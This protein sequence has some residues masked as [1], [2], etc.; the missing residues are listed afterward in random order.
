MKTLAQVEMLTPNGKFTLKKLCDLTG[1]QTQ[2]SQLP[3]RPVSLMHHQ[4]VISQNDFR[5]E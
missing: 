3:V 4:T 5:R 1:I 2:I